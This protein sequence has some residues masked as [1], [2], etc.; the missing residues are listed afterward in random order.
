MMIQANFDMVVIKGT[1]SDVSECC[2]YV[3]RHNLNQVIKVIQTMHNKKQVAVLIQLYMP[4]LDYEYRL[5][6]LRR[7]FL[8]CIRTQ[9]DGPRYGPT[10]IDIIPSLPLSAPVEIIENPSSSLLPL[11]VNFS[12]QVF[13]IIDANY[14]NTTEF[15]AIMRCDLFIQLDGN[16]N[17]NMVRLNELTTTFEIELYPGY[18][19]FPVLDVQSRRIA[20]LLLLNS[21][22]QPEAVLP[23]P[24]FPT[25]EILTVEQLAVREIIFRKNVRYLNA[26]FSLRSMG[27]LICLIVLVPAIVIAITLPIVLK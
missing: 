1:S 14:P 24:P 21:G 26:S 4:A 20:D 5:Y 25:R 9:R 11:L 13:G 23:F 6:F 17:P 7:E 27:F 8:Y 3:S 12:Q 16:G 19:T 22:I 15:S 2:E 18:T 10:G